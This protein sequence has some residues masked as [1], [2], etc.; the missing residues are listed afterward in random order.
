MN[1]WTKG[2][3]GG[4]DSP[5]DAYSLIEFNH[6]FSIVILKFNKGE[7]DNFHTHAFNALTWFI[8]G[9]LIEEGI[10]GSKYNYKN[11]IL[12]KVTKRIKNHRVKAMKDSWC[13]S[14]RGPWCNNWTEYDERSNE[15]TVF[16]HGREVTGVLRGLYKWGG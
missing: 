13:L 11:G 4:P 7:R 5:V 1:I 9:D 16:T 10:S 14:L 6:L 8:M 3:D 2:K 12:P 15:T